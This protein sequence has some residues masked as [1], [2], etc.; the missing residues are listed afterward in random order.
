MWAKIFST[1]LPEFWL[2]FL[3]HSVLSR[4]HR[5]GGHLGLVKNFKTPF[6]KD[7]ENF[8]HQV[9]ASTFTMST[10]DQTIWNSTPEL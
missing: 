4:G 10:H 9:E 5:E 6:F 7:I 2:L 8:F 3:S 1:I